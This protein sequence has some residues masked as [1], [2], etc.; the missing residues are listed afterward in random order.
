[1][2]E[3]DFGEPG[4][5]TVIDIGVARPR[6]GNPTNALELVDIPRPLMTC[7][8]KL[9]DG[10]KRQDLLIRAASLLRDRLPIQLALAGDGPTAGRLKALADELGVADRV[11][12]MG[13]LTR[14]RVFSLLDRTDIFVHPTEFEGSSKAVAEAMLC[15]K[16][17]IASDIGP[18]REHI[19]HGKTGL[20]AQNTAQAFATEIERV[21]SQ[22]ELRPTIQAGAFAYA[23]ENFDPNRNVVLY[24]QLFQEVVERS[25]S[26]TPAVRAPSASSWRRGLPR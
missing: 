2:A 21:C 24:E 10:S 14:H 16:A 22:P 6:E 17:I 3:L 13:N 26:A 18:I 20:L 11:H 25:R 23:T 1:M 19:V 15:G 12:F 4:D 7:V 8:A 9:K 5:S